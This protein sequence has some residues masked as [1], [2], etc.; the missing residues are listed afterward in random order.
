MVSRK[1]MGLW[2][3]FDVCLLA[4][5]VISIVFSI[6]YRKTDI[7]LNLTISKSQLLAALIMGIFLVVTFVFSIAAIVQKNHI[8][9]GLVI[10]NYMLIVDAFVV[11]CVGTFVWIW[12]LRQR[13]NYHPLYAALPPNSIAFIQDKFSCCG[14]FNGSDSVVPSTFCTTAQIAFT[15]AL[16]PTDV[17]NDNLFCVNAVTKFTDYTLNQMFSSAYGF[18]TIVLGLILFT[19]CIINMRKEDERFKRIDLKRGGKGFV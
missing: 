4:A 5:G 12:T 9:I 15:N 14:Y 18:M 13:N 11:L 7:L 8:T 17:N 19:L 2:A 3:L 1:L 6:V 10:L 16:D